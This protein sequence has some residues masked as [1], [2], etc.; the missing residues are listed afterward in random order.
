MHK[1]GVCFVIFIDFATDF[2]DPWWQDEKY[3]NMLKK[4]LF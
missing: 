3:I 1:S 4:N 2:S